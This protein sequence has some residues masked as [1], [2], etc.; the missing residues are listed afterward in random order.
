MNE[1]ASRSQLRMAF[2]RWALFCVS[3]ILLLGVGSGILSNSGYGNRWFAVLAKPDFTPPGWMFG[4]AWTLLY[5]LL[6]ISLAIVIGARGAPGRGLAITLF[7]VQLILN[8]AWSPLFFAA[9]EVALAFYLLLVILLLSV[10]TA[11]L[12]ARVRPIAAL[13]LLPYLAWLCFASYLSY[14]IH[15]M[16]PTGETLVAPGYSTQI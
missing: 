9:H 1:I 13:L 3:L 16:N 4:V 5:I 12:F 2:M 10:V 7:I 6:G 11:A 14:E 15:R 8:F